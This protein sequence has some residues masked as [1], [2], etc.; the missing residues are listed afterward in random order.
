MQVA[1][2]L[3]F[4]SLPWYPFSFC[5]VYFVLLCIPGLS[6]LFIFFCFYLFKFFIQFLKFTLHLQL[7]P[8]I[9]YIPHTVLHIPVADL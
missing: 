4:L 3:V 7:L 5:P 9:G 1:S 2:T 6:S 8:N